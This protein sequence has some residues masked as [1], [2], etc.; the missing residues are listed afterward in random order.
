MCV[1]PA[2]VR[3][4]SIPPT[5]VAMYGRVDV[6]VNSIH[7]GGVPGGGA[8]T[9]TYVSSDGSSLGFRGA[10]DLGDNAR[11]YFK[12]EHW[13]NADTGTQF[14]PGQFWSREAYLGIGQASLGY[15]QLGSQYGPGMWVSLK[16][17][18]FYRAS[19]GAILTLF[20]ATPGNVRG[21]ASTLNNAVQYATPTFAGFTARLM[22]TAPEGATPGRST[23]LHLDYTADRL[24]A[25]LSVD[26]TKLNGAA[27]AQ[28]AAATVDQTV[29][30]VG[31]SYRFDGVKLHGYAMQS[32]VEGLPKLHGYMLGATVPLGLGEI[33]AS[34]SR[35][36]TAAETDAD[37]SLA[38]AG[39]FYF[40]SKRTTIYALVSRLNNEGTARF[41]LWPSSVDAGSAWPRAGE[42]LTGTQIGVRHAF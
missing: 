20:Q 2:L 29:V 38:A 40:L 3:A 7:Y 10:E 42:H 41:G 33:R 22:V 15:V 23:H 18:P 31:A 34:W 5:G 39:Y 26:R 14:S 12:L 35:R 25:G 6:S 30:T 24:F 13:F 17:D 19:Q 8:R 11:A 36:R 28:P 4:Q 27:A 9:G 21:F 32:D 1:L 37:A 16:A